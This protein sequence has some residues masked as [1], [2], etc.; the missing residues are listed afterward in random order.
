M[1]DTIKCGWWV[2][3]KNG[4]E[5]FVSGLALDCTNNREGNYVVEY[6]KDGIRYVRDTEEFLQK[7]TYNA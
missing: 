5:Y 1:V 7:F 4:E 2:N 3:N 6:Q